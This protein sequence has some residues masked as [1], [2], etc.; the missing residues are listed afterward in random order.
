MGQNNIAGSILQSLLGWVQALF[1]G[2]WSLFSGGSGGSL[3]KWLSANWLSMLVFF[4][5]LGV[6]LDVVIYLIRWRPFWGWFRKK[7]LVIDD[8]IFDTKRS[9]TRKPSSRSASTRKPSTYIPK[10][11]SKYDDFDEE[12]DVFEVK[13]RKKKD[14]FEVDHMSGTHTARRT[15]RR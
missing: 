10:R 8:E 12:D 3:L 13:K 1:N 9:S 15:S 11:I 4:L 2:V 7:R 6:C 5:A 14:V